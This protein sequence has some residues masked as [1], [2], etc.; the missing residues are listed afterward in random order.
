MTS[1]PETRAV[2]D[3]MDALGAV[4]RTVNGIRFY[5]VDEDHTIPVSEL[6]LTVNGGDAI[7]FDR[8]AVEMDHD[9]GMARA[10]LYATP[11]DPEEDR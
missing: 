4:P 6:R 1:G 7:N 3:A 2:A 10:Y 5:V 11:T 8:I 9:D